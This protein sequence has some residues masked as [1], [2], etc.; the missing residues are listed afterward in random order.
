[1]I[2][3]TWQSRGIDPIILTKTI[4]RYLQ[5]LKDK[6]VLFY[7]LFDLSFWDLLSFICSNVLHFFILF[8]SFVFL[9]LLRF[10]GHHVKVNYSTVLQMND[11]INLRKRFNILQGF[12]PQKMG[13]AQTKP[14][15]WNLNLFLVNLMRPQLADQCHKLSI[16]S[17]REMLADLHAESEIFF[18][19]SKKSLQCIEST[20][21]KGFE[22][23][24]KRS[25][26]NVYLGECLLLQ[27]VAK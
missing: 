27:V 25:A 9:S 16:K 1:M 19:G 22:W 6:T 3:T 20:F 15:T 14:Q 2:I 8:L 4:L 17:C 11:K 21:V 10:T 26:R 18:S 23:C 13:E 5:I 12:F 24:L 7:R